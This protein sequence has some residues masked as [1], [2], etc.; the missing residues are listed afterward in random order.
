MRDFVSH[1]ASFRS[2][3]L[4]LT[5]AALAAAPAAAQVTVYYGLLDVG[6]TYVSNESGGSN[7]KLNSGEL[8]QSRLGFTGVED[9]GGGYKASFRLESGFDA[10]TGI[11]VPA[12]T[13]WSRESSLTLTTPAGALSLG[14]Q[15]PSQMDFIYKF[16]ALMGVYGPGYYSGHPGNYDWAANAVVDN[17]A[18]YTSP[19]FGGFRFGASYGFPERT[20]NKRVSFG[21]GYESG[22]FSIGTGYV[23]A[24]GVSNAAIFLAPAANPFSAANPAD[25]TKTVGLGASFA[26]GASL[27]H[28][29]ATQTEFETSSRKAR[30]YELGTKWVVPGAPLWTLGGDYSHTRVT[31][32]NAKANLVTL[33][34]VYALSKR[35]D[36][37]GTLAHERVSGTN[38]GG[39]PLVAQILTQGASSTDSQSVFRL[40]IRH[41]F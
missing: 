14:R 39:T 26:F 9:L 33:S 4:L 13:F 27:V 30:S 28:A 37:Y 7:K 18:K 6:L 19:N 38:V 16:S 11:T 25:E 32:G 35:T 2:A 24:G 15:G 3:A 31:N 17:S 20:P 21:A 41:R 10:S 1:P 34:A 22:P 23:K 5:G 40:A 36:I 8:Q 12:T 29:L